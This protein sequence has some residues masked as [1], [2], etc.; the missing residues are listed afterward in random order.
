VLFA[1]LRKHS[2]S[3][4][5]PIGCHAFVNFADVLREMLLNLGWLS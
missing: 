2:G 1:W 5:L 4:L 3:T